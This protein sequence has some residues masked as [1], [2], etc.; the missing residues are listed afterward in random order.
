M[1]NMNWPNFSH[2]A[3]IGYVIGHEMTHGFDKEGS[4][5]DEYGTLNMNIFCKCCIA[6]LFC[7]LHSFGTFHLRCSY[8]VLAFFSHG[9][10]QGCG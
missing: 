5:Y 8:V 10:T 9:P 7:D 1:L 2:L 3:S 4:K 6:K